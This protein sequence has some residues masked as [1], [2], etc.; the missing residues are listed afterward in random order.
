MDGTNCAGIRRQGRLLQA[1]ASD[2]G[3]EA[4][5]AGEAND[6]VHDVQKRQN[7]YLLTQIGVLR[8]ES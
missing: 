4:S 5:L 8:S 2:F 3:V 6:A 1:P 7:P